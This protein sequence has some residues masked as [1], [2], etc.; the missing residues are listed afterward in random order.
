MFGLPR[1][2][3]NLV[4]VS[5][6]PPTSNGKLDYQRLIETGQE[7]APVGTRRRKQ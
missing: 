5:E 2:A 3:V 6:L 4:V 1:T 7:H